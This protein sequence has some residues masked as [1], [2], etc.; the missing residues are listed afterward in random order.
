MKRSLRNG[1]ALLAAL[2]VLCGAAVPTIALAENIQARE[3]KFEAVVSADQMSRIAIEGDKIV[4]VRT[5][6]DPDGP[7]MLVEA[8]ESTGEVYVAFDGDVLGRTFTLFLVT[9]S[10]RTVQATL[11]PSSVSGQS[12][13]VNLGANPAQAAGDTVS[14]SEKRNGYMETVTAL[15]RLMFNSEAPDGVRRTG[16]AAQPTRVGPYEL[17][18]VET[19]E[20]AGLRGQVMAIKNASEATVPVVVDSFLVAGVMAAATDRPE[21]LPGGEARI[22]LVE[23]VR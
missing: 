23:E 5:I 2:T 6:N 3:G 16:R 18:I 20:V 11:S 21:L 13:T 19:Y 17:R 15:V 7:Q 14:R 1:V 4:S 9:A 22:F 12:V 10:G 8:E